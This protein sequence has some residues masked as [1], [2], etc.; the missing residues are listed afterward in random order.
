VK[1]SEA[2]PSL[3]FDH[4]RSSCATDQTTGQK[5]QGILLSDQTK[6]E[7]A[8]RKRKRQKKDTRAMTRS[9]PA[10]Q[11]KEAQKKSA[12]KE[13]RKRAQKKGSRKRKQKKD[14][15]FRKSTSENRKRTPTL[16]DAEKGRS[17]KRT[18]S[19]AEK[20]HPLYWTQKKQQQ[21]KDTHFTRCLRCC[22]VG[23]RDR[24]PYVGRNRNQSEC[25][26]SSFSFFLSLR[27]SPTK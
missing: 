26:L 1:A 2:M 11:K 17:R 10:A 8:D 15:H 9:A 5:Q 19:R 12:E 22:V 24:A 13:R 27:R 25:P 4:F 7:K 6:T 20:G 23:Q 21:K 16:L 14:T 3:D 18:P